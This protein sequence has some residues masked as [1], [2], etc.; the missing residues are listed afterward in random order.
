[1]ICP[2]AMWDAGASFLWNNKNTQEARDEQLTL[3]SLFRKICVLKNISILRDAQLNQHQ[4]RLYYV[5]KALR[6]LLALSAK[7]EGQAED[8]RFAVHRGRRLEVKQKLEE[9]LAGLEF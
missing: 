3:I 8:N 1:M 7:Q 4:S 2:V 5:E 9:R 6:F